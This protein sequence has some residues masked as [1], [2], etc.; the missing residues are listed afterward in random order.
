MLS[1]LESKNDSRM[2]H[3]N[4]CSHSRRSAGDGEFLFELLL[5][6]EACVVAV[7]GEQLVVLSDLHNPSMV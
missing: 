6:I 2:G 3:P 5:L 1:P 7:E 4:Y